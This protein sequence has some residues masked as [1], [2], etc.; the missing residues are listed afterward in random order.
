MWREL[1]VYHAGV[2]SLIE[3]DDVSKRAALPNRL[4]RVTPLSEERNYRQSIFTIYQGE[5]IGRDPGSN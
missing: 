3:K 5:G 2:N 4:E 1:T